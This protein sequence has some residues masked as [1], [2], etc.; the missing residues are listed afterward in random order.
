MQTKLHDL[1]ILLQGGHFFQ[2]VLR[3]A[4]AR[5]RMMDHDRHPGNLFG[6]PPY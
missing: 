3:E 2:P 6:R 5:K 1:N 4:E